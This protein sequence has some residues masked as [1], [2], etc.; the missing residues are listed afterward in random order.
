ML[1]EKCPKSIIILHLAYLWCPNRHDTTNGSAKLLTPLGTGYY[2]IINCQQFILPSMWH[3]PRFWCQLA[4]FH[5]KDFVFVAGSAQVLKKLVLRRSRR[6]LNFSFSLNL[7]KSRSVLDLSSL[8]SEYSLFKNI[9]LRFL[10]VGRK[11]N[12]I[13]FSCLICHAAKAAWKP[14]LRVCL[15]FRSLGIGSS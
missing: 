11:V 1:S 13:L 4:Q 9:L 2:R 14:S 12:E 8:A 10:T 5:I 15:T 6:F 7:L 3:L